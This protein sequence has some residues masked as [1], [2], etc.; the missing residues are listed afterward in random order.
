MSRS[1]RSAAATFYLA[2]WWVGRA[3]LRPA[4]AALLLAGAFAPAVEAVGQG[5][6]AGT[7]VDGNGAPLGEVKV[8]VTSPDM[9]AYRLEKL[10]D[11]RGQFNA[12]ILDAAPLYRIR[13]EKSGYETLEQPLKLKI[14]DTLKETYILQSSQPPAD[15]PP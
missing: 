11:G 15:P 2:P 13:F 4:L 10:T 8:I 14:E 12:V 3:C 6:V 1:V 9:P 5:R 7:V